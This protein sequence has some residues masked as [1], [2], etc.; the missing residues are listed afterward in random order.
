MRGVP[1]PPVLREGWAPVLQEGLLGTLWG[2]VPWL[3]RADH[4]GAGYGEHHRVPRGG[5]WSLVPW[6]SSWGA[7]EVGKG[8]RPLSTTGRGRGT[9]YILGDPGGLCWGWG[10]QGRSSRWW[11]VFLQPSPAWWH[12]CPHHPMAHPDLPMVLVHP[13]VLLAPPR[14]LDRGSWG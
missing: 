14:C 3:L 11:E 10:M 9:L 5:T 7:G 12:F 2:A 4:Q 6:L 8:C 13:W 1:V